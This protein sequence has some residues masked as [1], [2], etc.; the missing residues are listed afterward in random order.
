MDSAHTKTFLLFQAHLSRIELPSTDYNTDLKSVLDQAMRILQAMIDVCAE[1]GFLATALR[2][3]MIVQG[4]VQ[5]AWPDTTSIIT[6]P[7]V[8]LPLA[9]KLSTKFAPTLPELQMFVETQPRLLKS[10]L[11]TELRDNQVEKV[12]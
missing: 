1:Y 4:I 6:L 10:L 7:F 2:T 3:Q 11:Q 5:A 12:R 8:E 9:Q